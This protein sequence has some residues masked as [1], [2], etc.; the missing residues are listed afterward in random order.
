MA[1][2]S[3]KAFI[4]N[5]LHL[6]DLHFEVDSTHVRKA[7]RSA[8]NAS[9][10]QTLGEIIAKEQLTHPTARHREDDWTPDLVAVSGDIAFSGHRDDYARAEDFGS[11]GVIVGEDRRIRRSARAS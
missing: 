3:D 6:S 8:A 7:H 9:L 1:P 5:L 10:L 4:V 2:W 11:P